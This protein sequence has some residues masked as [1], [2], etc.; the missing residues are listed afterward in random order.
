[1]NLHIIILVVVIILILTGLYINNLYSSE[2][3]NSDLCPEFL[4]KNGNKFELW[5]DKAI[6]RV[7][8]SYSDYLKYYHFTKDN[9]IRKNNKCAPLKPAD[10][11]AG[12]MSRLLLNT[13]NLLSRFFNIE[14]FENVTTK[15]YYVLGL[16]GQKFQNDKLNTLPT[17]DYTI[18]VDSTSTL[19]PLTDDTIV[20]RVLSLE[21]LE[22]LSIK[23]NTVEYLIKK[24]G[25]SNFEVK[26]TIAN[27]MHVYRFDSLNNINTIQMS[28]S[29]RP[30]NT[31]NIRIYYIYNGNT[32]LITNSVFDAGVTYYV[33]KNHVDQTQVTVAPATTT[34]T[35][36]ETTPETTTVTTETTQETTPVTTEEIVPL[37]EE[38]MYEEVPSE[39]VPVAEETTKPPVAETKPQMQPLMNNSSIYN[40][41]NTFNTDNKGGIYITPGDNQRVPT[42]TTVI[43]NT[44]P[45]TKDM[46]SQS[47]DN[48][49][50]KYSK[51]ISEIGTHLQDID[52]KL[53]TLNNEISGMRQYDSQKDS[54]INTHKSLEEKA[55][56]SL[57]EEQA[58]KTKINKDNSTGYANKSTD[59][60]IHS[61]FNYKPEYEFKHMEPSKEILS[62]Y[63]WSYMPPQFWSVPQKRPPVCIPDK[64]AQATV[65]PIYDKSVPVDAL[66]WTQV[67]SI[68]PKF[69]YK[70]VYN[71]NYYYPGWIAQ[72]EVKYPFDGK[73]FS[74]QYY[75]YNL[76]EK[77]EK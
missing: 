62:A 4:Y 52:F 54:F 25:D 11:P 64:T 55:T 72:D 65:T 51:Y 6:V 14:H 31:G 24:T 33:L 35:T 7:F 29:T 26:G 8:D 74:S 47:V 75:S 46:Y 32:E 40:T 30:E 53:N 69:E 21:K 66:E 76:A 5:K 3:F 44:R 9:Y 61:N 19:T 68:L 60:N 18:S 59:N 77:V 17:F 38:M 36:Q 50:N 67:G 48:Q 10:K 71:P 34:V 42:I 49:F 39:E 58:I 1:M 43:N 16:F 28:I 41:P 2:H 13:Q 22:P 37:E 20:N 70:E 63:G 23:N 27:D 57:M 73:K 56:K 45:V 12:L 15:G